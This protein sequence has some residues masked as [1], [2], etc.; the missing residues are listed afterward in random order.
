MVQSADKRWR[1]AL[2]VLP[3]LV[4]LVAVPIVTMP[5]QSHSTLE[6]GTFIAGK[7]YIDSCTMEGTLLGRTLH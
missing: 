5:Q 2:L 6:G 4:V 7:C 3:L 1:N